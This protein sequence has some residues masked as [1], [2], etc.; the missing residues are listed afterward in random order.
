M[1]RRHMKSYGNLK[2]YIVEYQ[3]NIWILLHY[4]LPQKMFRVTGL[5]ENIITPKPLRKIYLKAD[6]L[7]FIRKIIKFH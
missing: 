1:Q 3:I 5:K 6:T 7:N 4:S 2:N